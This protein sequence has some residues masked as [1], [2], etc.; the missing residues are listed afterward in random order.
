MSSFV[1]LK[2]P[3]TADEIASLL[4]LADYCIHYDLDYCTEVSDELKERTSRTSW[5]ST[6]GKLYRVLESYGVIKPSLSE[7]KQQGSA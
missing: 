6:V 1:N 5:K 4:G 2:K 3:W 7:F